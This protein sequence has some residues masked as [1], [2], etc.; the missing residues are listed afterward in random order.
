M[1]AAVAT[2]FNPGICQ[3]RNTISWGCPVASAC[4]TASMAADPPSTAV[5]TK[6]MLRSC[7]VSTSRALSLSSTTSTR[8]PRRSGVGTSGTSA[9]SF[10]DSRTV[11]QK[12]DPLPAV[13]STPT[14]P[15]ISSASRLLIASPSP[16][17]PKR[18]VV[19]VSAC[20]K[21]RNRRSRWA[22]SSPMPVSATSKRSSSSPLLRW[23]TRARRVISPCSVNLTALLA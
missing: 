11:N 12:V 6:V 4:C 2:P 13:L 22:S 1:R 14:V 16:V 7:S 19:E 21:L 9:A 23:A 20:S 5:T 10:A 3:S 18:R 17:P 8:R 15:P